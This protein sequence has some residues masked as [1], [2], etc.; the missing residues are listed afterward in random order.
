MQ[1]SAAAQDTD[2][3]RLPSA[4][5][6]RMHVQR[7]GAEPLGSAGCQVLLDSA[8]ARASVFLALTPAQASGCWRPQGNTEA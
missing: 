3:K 5:V 4:P 1:G 7:R 6:H 8:Q 2:G